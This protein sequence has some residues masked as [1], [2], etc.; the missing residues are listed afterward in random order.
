M[1]LNEFLDK[2]EDD[3]LDEAKYTSALEYKRHWKELSK[4]EADKYNKEHGTHIHGYWVYDHREAAG[5]TY[6][7]NTVVHHK[8]HDKHN[9]HKRNLM[10]ISRAD[11]CIVDPNALKHKGEKCKEKGCG[12]DY[13]AKG[14]CYKHYMKHYR[15]KDL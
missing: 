13:Y 12:N 9:N 1:N 4:E 8:D 7:D 6:G 15:K 2:T 10:K 3:I 5:A 14:Y 11:H